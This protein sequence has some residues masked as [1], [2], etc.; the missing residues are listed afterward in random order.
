MSKILI[1]CVLPILLL[2]NILYAQESTSS[3]YSRFGLGDLTTQFLPVF[4]SLGGGVAIYNDKI[5]NPYSPA[6]YTAFKPNSFL[7]STGVS[8]NMISINSLSE[9]QLV[10]NTS[11]SHIII[12]CPINK[13]IGAS[14]GIIPFSSIGYTLNSR[15]EFYNA[16]MFYYGD[17]GIS[18]VYL[19]GA[20][21]LH[22]N[23]SLGINASYL[24]GGLNSC[25]LYTSP[26]PRDG[27]LSRM[28]SSA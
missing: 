19:G 8:H 5:I 25:L 16:D 7:F 14:A 23:L 22:D 13:R 1:K 24:F 17:G 10:N 9:T 15:D 11:L 18:K 2:N 27:L 6:T 20:L 4:N 12:A 3:P 26:S 28:P 21:K